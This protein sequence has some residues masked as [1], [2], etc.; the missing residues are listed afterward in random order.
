MPHRGSSSLDE[1]V[2]QLLLVHGLNSE[3]VDK[4]KEFAAFGNGWHKPLLHIAMLVGSRLTARALPA[5]DECSSP[6]VDG[7]RLKIQR[8]TGASAG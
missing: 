7:F 1:Q 5:G 8:P 6:Q 3:D 4:R 2:D